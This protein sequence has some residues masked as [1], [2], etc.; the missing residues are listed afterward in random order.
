MYL[1]IIYQYFKTGFISADA[2]PSVLFPGVKFRLAIFLHS[3]VAHKKRL[4][5]TKYNRW[6][7]EARDNLFYNLEYTD[8]PFKLNS[9]LPKII[10]PTHLR[11]LQKLRNNKGSIGTEGKGSHAA[12]FHNAPVNWIRAHSFIPY[13]VSERDGEKAS[14]QLK[15]L[16]FAKQEQALAC[17]GMLCSTLFF[18]WWLTTS[19]CYHLN[20]KEID[21]ILI[22]LSDLGFVKQLAPIAK[23]LNDDMQAK[24]K[25]R[26]Y[27]YETSGR[28]EYDEFYL[29]LSKPL[30]DQIDCLLAQHYG[31]THEELDFIINYDIKY[32]MGKELNNGEEVEE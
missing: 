28:V 17:S 1:F 3:N 8:A 12:Y 15:P 19:D 23:K 25:R 9:V 29:K 11:I 30:I 6:Y 2:N 24:S 21:N 31:F 32:R 16:T 4:F 22:D 20:R 7:A 18:I 27:I 10:S 14:T 5:T 13:F 26:V